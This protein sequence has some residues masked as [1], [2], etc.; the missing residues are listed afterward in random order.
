MIAINESYQLCPWAD[1]L[2][3]CDG[4]WWTL[5][6]GVPEFHG[7]KIS[8]DAEACKRYPEI[9][10]VDVDRYSNELKLHKWGKIGAGGN[11]GFQ[12]L[13]SCGSVRL[14]EDLTRRIRHANG[15]WGTLA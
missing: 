2:Y 11:G 13:K 4:N 15:F 14:H 6:S 9:K 5:K 12:A 8:Q 7:L 1:V 10:K 3:A